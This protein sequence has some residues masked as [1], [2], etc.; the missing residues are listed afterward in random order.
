MT[1]EGKRGYQGQV[2]Y[3]QTFLYYSSSSPPWFPLQFYWTFLDAVLLPPSCFALED[4]HSI[5]L[6]ETTDSIYP[7]LNIFHKTVRVA[8]TARCKCSPS[9]Q[10]PTLHHRGWNHAKPAELCGTG[11]P[12][13]AFDAHIKSSA[14][15]SA[16][17]TSFP[18]DQQDQGKW[19][20]GH[21][22]LCVCFYKTQNNARA[23]LIKM[24]RLQTHKI[25]MGSKRKEH[26]VIWKAI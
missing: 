16:A 20:R 23:V 22:G 25:E 18:G 8:F 5:S 13:T 26:C 1:K 2:R 19:V 15:C 9:P 17:A 6:C 21:H 11:G 14:S 10:H 3:S 7:Q 12:V 4:I 24:Y